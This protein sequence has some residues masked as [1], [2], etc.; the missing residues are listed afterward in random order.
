MKKNFHTHTNYCKH[1]NLTIEESIRLHREAGYT[2]LGISEHI[3]IPGMEDR[4]RLQKDQV[5][6]Y[7]EEVKKAAE[8]EEEM[9]VL[10]GLEA[11]YI[12]GDR[13]H[14]EY[15][16][17]LR[18][19]VDYMILANHI[20]GDLKG[21]DYIHFARTDPEERHLHINAQLL[22]EGWET[23]LFAFIAHPD[24]ILKRYRWDK[25]AERM[26]H[27]IGEFAQETGALLEMNANGIR[28]GNNRSV[29]EGTNAYTNLNFWRIV[30]QYNVNVIISGDTHHDF[31]VGD[32]MEEEAR[33]LAESLGLNIVEDFR[34]L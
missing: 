33:R 11:E 3:P 32:T 9:E 1:S 6:I 22:K 17:M 34:E 31:Q 8:K 21:E 16:K 29:E 18:K 15:L 13:E 20:V 28:S 10:C 27:T 12:L 19:K 14:L 30:A 23:G 25:E 4:F 7:I 26:A 5:D 2:T 24:S